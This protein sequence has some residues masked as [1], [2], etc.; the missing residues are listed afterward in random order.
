MNLI[1]KVVKFGV[2]TQCGNIRHTEHGALLLT[3]NYACS[4]LSRAIALSE[5]VRIHISLDGAAELLSR[6]HRQILHVVSPQVGCF[7][8]RRSLGYSSKAIPS[9]TIAIF[10]SS[11]VIRIKYALLVTGFIESFAGLV[12]SKERGCCR[13]LNSSFSNIRL[14]RRDLVRHLYSDVR[15]YT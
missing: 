13:H 3:N 15:V 4:N 10:L 1:C 11:C 8:A 12:P 14:R 9:H 2:I 5:L 6:P 7:S